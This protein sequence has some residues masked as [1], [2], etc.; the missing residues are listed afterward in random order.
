M[1]KNNLDEMQEQKLLHIEKFGFWFAYLGL[2]IAIVVQIVMG[3]DFKQIA[4]E[5]IVFMPVCFITFIRCVRN[6]IWDRHLKPNFKTNLLLSIITSF[7][8][9]LVYGISKYLQ[10][11]ESINGNI[12]GDVI[13]ILI[14]S[15][16]LFF[17]FL[18]VSTHL[19]KRRVRKIEDKTND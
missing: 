18:Q 6:G 12:I 16:I 3:A 19:Y 11:K 4:G 17:V 7:A 13:Y 8:F 2:F 14:I 10:F 9:G 5:W 15:S 1:M